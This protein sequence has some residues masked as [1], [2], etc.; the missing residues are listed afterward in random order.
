MIQIKTNL[1]QRKMEHRE[2]EMLQKFINEITKI[3]RIT[4]EEET[5]LAQ[6]IQSGDQRALD[7]LVSTNLR[8]VISVA[9]QYQNLGLPL[10]DLVNEANIG[11][12]KAAKR[13]D[14]SKGFKFISYGVWW[15][16]QA[17]LEALAEQSRIVRVPAPTISLFRKAD[18][19]SLNFTQLN[20]REPTTDEL[21][22]MM[23]LSKKRLDLLMKTNARTVYIDAPVGDD[24]PSGK[25]KGDLL[26][27]S[28]KKADWEL[29]SSSFRKEVRAL[30]NKLTPK[31]AD[32]IICTFKLDGDE[33]ITKEQIVQKYK[34]K[35]VDSIQGV[36]DL[37]LALLQ[38]MPEAKFLSKLYGIKLK[39]I[40]KVPRAA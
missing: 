22:E 6:K 27:K 39:K 11:L 31:Q 28:D 1:N 21:A 26:L 7:K 34:L 37:T 17:I 33:S 40:R 30:L 3:P 5:V 19:L 18:Q 23:K 10:G 36:K 16:R 24:D 8:F 2:N 32:V 9:K 38:N 15:S 14:E 25:T 4:P 12:I 20:E 13:F 35:T 29:N